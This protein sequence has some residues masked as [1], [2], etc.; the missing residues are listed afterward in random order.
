MV[1]SVDHG[2]GTPSVLAARTAASGG[3]CLKNSATAGLLALDKYHG[4]AVEDCMGVLE[5]VVEKSR[6]AASPCTLD[7]AAEYVINEIRG[8][9]ERVSGFGHRQ[10]THDPR[11]D[12]LFELTLEAGVEG[13]YIQASKAITQAL[14]K[15]IGKDLPI[16][17]DGAVATILCELHYPKGLGNAPFLIAR[18]T[19]ILAHSY[20]EIE[21][22]PRMRRIDPIDHGY[23][24]PALRK[25]TPGSDA[26]E[27]KKPL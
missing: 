16:N 21:K 25:L 2:A 9:G 5:K 27:G 13:I 4:A 14:K 8:N 10:H 1:A 12:R 19:G 7:E 18:F 20:E 17:I 23:C 22:M 3:A 24:G 6:S 26:D 11:V 15:I